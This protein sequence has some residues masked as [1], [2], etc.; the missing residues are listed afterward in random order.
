[1]ASLRELSFLAAADDVERWSDALL[2]A[3]AYS[4]QAEDADADSPDE[5]ALYGEPG[6]PAARIGWQRTRLTALLGDGIGA[7]QMLAVA[8]RALGLP[9]PETIDVRDV[10]DQDW[11]SASQSQFAPIPVGHRLL[12][13]PSWHLPADG[14]PADVASAGV[15]DR[16]TIVLDPGLAF[17]TGSHPTTHLCLQWLGEHLQPGESVIDYGCGSGILAI[18]AAKLGA[19]RVVAIDIDPQALASTTSNAAINGVRVEVQPTSA[20]APA[21]ADVVVANILSNPLK[22]L[23]PLLSTLVRP[24]GRLVLAGLLE[25]QVGEVSAAYPA[26]DLSVYEAMDGWACLAGIRR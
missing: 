11:V 6:M 25:R 26:V 10:P 23:A 15:D 1:L 9:L 4:V 19:S 7:E 2:E 16:I 17:G 13:T 22:V 20:L 18:A 12:I 14:T 5:Q 24:G 8:A 21:P 3:G